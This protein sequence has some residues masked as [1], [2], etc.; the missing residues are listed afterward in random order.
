[1]FE[2]LAELKD[3]REVFDFEQ[4]GDEQAENEKKETEQIKYVLIALDNREGNPADHSEEQSQYGIGGDEAEE[5]KE[6]YEQGFFL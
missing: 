5:K 4:A 6:G 1:V 3:T 2:A